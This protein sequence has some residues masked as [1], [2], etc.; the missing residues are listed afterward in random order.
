MR[1]IAVIKMNILF[2]IR[3][4]APEQAIGYT[5]PYIE[6]LTEKDGYRQGD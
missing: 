4:P 2:Q 3:W 1:N 6:L 5:G